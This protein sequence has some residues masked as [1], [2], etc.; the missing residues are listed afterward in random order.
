MK[1]LHVTVHFRSGADEHVL[2]DATPS[3]RW[4]SG[5]L[6]TLVP[7][8]AANHECPKTVF[9]KSW[10]VDC[11]SGPAAMSGTATFTELIGSADGALVSDPMLPHTIC[12]ALM[13]SFGD[14]LLNGSLS[15]LD[16]ASWTVK[17]AQ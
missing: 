11:S 5:D 3:C 2:E 4:V 10:I 14:L 8:F 12:K 17:V 7:P 15:G 13:C 6:S 9:G 1:T 16:L